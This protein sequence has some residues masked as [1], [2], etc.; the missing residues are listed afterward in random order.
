MCERET[1]KYALYICKK[2]NN[3]CF[4]T[5]LFLLSSFGEHCKALS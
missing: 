3:Y 4:I 1:K 5:A 2:N